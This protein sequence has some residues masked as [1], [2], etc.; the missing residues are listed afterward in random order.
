MVAFRLKHRGT[1]QTLTEL[2]VGSVSGGLSWL[3]GTL[4]LE[5]DIDAE[6]SFCLFGVA[7]E[8]SEMDI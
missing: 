4:F 8:I 7:E 1:L 6:F 2:L 5:R 3:E